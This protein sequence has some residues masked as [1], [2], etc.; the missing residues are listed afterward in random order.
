MV[1]PFIDDYIHFTKSFSKITVQEDE[2]ELKVPEKV[3]RCIWNDQLVDASKLE[4]TAGE[5]L[6][7][8]F[9]GYWNFGPG[10]DFKSAAIKVNGRLYE[11]DLEIHVRSGDWKAHGH[12]NNPDFDNVLFH[13]FLWQTGPV[14]KPFDPGIK[15]DERR[16]GQAGPFFELELKKYLTRGLLDL[17]ENLDFD[18]YPIMN[19]FNHGLCHRPLANLPREKLLRLLDAAG[20]AR[21]LVKMDRF[22][23]R[24]IVNGYE[25]TFYEGV[26]E[27]LG[28]PNNKKP[29]RELAERAPLE[30]L[31]KL[32]PRKASEEER[33]LRIQAILLGVAGLA[34]FSALDPE[35]LEPEERS[36]FQ[37]LDALWQSCRERIKV[38]PLPRS[39]WKFKGIRPANYPY[40]RIV[41]LS[42]LLAQ[43]LK[44]GMF[45]D[46]MKTFQQA[47]SATEKKGYTLKIP[48]TLYDY[49]CVPG[50]GYWATHYT[51]GGKRLK[52][53]QNLIG[54][55]RSS[56][57]IVNIVMPIALIHARAVKSSN[58]EIALN[59]LYS[60]S[61]GGAENH[62]MRFMKYYILGDN[63]D[64]IRLVANDRQRQGLMQVYQDFCT[65]NSN[66]C[67]RCSFP[68]VIRQFLT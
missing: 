25:Q 45:F 39:C 11:G 61:R 19:Q 27:A 2:R 16:P 24:V 26:A 22:H 21:I 52:S 34:N 41:G 48:K 12:S 68:E 1:S 51:P 59:Q 18:S 8:V 63:A 54:S 23:D 20:D 58:L 62:K 64:M 36:Y 42:H 57:I 17:S 50:V 38:E 5:S 4:T 35:D 65:Q 29:F 10:P 15:T 33:A 43:R 30:A 47:A 56:E 67:L 53:P 37:R 46:F 55:S 66:N 60:S 6:E 32:L 40:R 13:V 28:Y 44:S 7:V 9:P 3:V 14:A 49:F 31:R